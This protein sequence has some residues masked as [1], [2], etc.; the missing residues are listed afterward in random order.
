MNRFFY[1]A[2]GS[3]MACG[4]MGERCPG[5]EL[6]GAARL[7]GYR[8]AFTRFSEN[9]RCGV[10]D[11]V[12]DPAA[13][14]WGVLYRVSEDDLAQ[15]D[16]REGYYGPGGENAYNRKTVEVRVPEPEGERTYAG[17]QTYVVAKPRFAADGRAG[18]YKP[19]PVYKKVMTCAA[20]NRRLP[21]EYITTLEG[22]E[23]Q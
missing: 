23:T 4:Q 6:V 18:A 3:N 5:A 12:P 8:L 13:E 7:V 22:W 10:A 17:V 19:G 16:K 11:A 21:R 2:Y 14:I 9:W 20:E 1:F 15:L